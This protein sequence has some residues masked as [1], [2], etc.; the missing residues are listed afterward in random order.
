[1]AGMT[2]VSLEGFRAADALSNRSLPLAVEDSHGAGYPGSAAC[3][4]GLQPFMRR[5]SESRE[6]SGA[7]RQDCVSS[8]GWPR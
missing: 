7:P 1:M 8:V 3:A 2:Y 6:R 5:G 4:D